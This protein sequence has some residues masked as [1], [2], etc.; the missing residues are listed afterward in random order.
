MFVVLIGSKYTNFRNREVS[1]VRKQSLGVRGKKKNRKQEKAITGFNSKCSVKV[2]KK[3][4]KKT[5]TVSMED[6]SNICV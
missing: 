1:L 4:Q 3:I 2:I 5:K 6:Y